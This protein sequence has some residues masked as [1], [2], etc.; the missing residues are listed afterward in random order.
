MSAVKECHKPRAY[1][2][3]TA[4]KG[5]VFNDVPPSVEF[6]STCKQK[7][8]FRGNCRVLQGLGKALVFILRLFK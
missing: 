8:G 3:Q 4:N 7:G 6:K 1:E 2:A 5:D